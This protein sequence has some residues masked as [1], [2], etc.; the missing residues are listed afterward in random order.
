MGW[1]GKE[2]YIFLILDAFETFTEMTS[3]IKHTVLLLIFLQ[4][5]AHCRSSDVGRGP[6][7]LLKNLK[8]WALTW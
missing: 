5:N 1:G 7:I 3:Y 4:T 2:Y 8:N 6:K